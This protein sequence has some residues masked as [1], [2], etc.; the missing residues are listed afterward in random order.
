MPLIILFLLVPL[1]ELYVMIEVGQDIGAIS[2]IALTLFT[3]AFGLMLTRLQ[4]LSVLL[5]VRET[6]QRGEV[7]ALEVLE[8]AALMLAGLMLFL[9]GF[10]TDTLGFILLIAPI[11]RWLL[12]GFLRRSGVQRPVQGQPTQGGS[13][14]QGRIIDGEYHKED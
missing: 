14:P 8:G 2:T 3:A 4:G 1:I 7:P 9:P 6:M 5:R 12:Y 11:R 13:Q 10:I